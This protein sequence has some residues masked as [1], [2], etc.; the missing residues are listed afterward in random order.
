VVRLYEQ[1]ALLRAAGDT[2]RPG[3]LTLTRQLIEACDLPRGASVLDIGCGIGATVDYLSDEFHAFGVDVSSKLLHLGRQRFPSRMLLRA[4]GESLPVADQSLDAVLME[5]SLSVMLDTDCA[6]REC[7]RVLKPGGKLAI[8]DLYV[9]N[10]AGVENL[11]RLTFGSCVRG[12]LTK[13]DLLSRLGGFDLMLWEDH[14]QALKAFTAQLIFTYGSFEQ[15]WCSSA[16]ASPSLAITQAKP[17]YCLLIAQ[18]R[19]FYG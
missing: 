7:W 15:F 17:G 19:A 2:I 6:I 4:S 12:A 8:S 18:R 5:C 13:E 16:C 3:Q 1:D 9:R 10:P 11:R 14:T